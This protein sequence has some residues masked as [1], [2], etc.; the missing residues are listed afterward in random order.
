MSKLNY[1]LVTGFYQIQIIRT[2]TLSTF[3]A[4]MN[5]ALHVILNS[6]N[7]PVYIHC[8]D[9]RRVT[10]VLILLLRRLQLW[11]PQSAFAEYWR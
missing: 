7:N 8:L 11:A 4:S 9:G 2:G 10:S 6:D 1:R 3:T 5:K